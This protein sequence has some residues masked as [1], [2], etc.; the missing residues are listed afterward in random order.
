MHLA[1]GDDDWYGPSSPYRQVDWTP[2]V[3]VFTEARLTPVTVEDGMT[4][5]AVRTTALPAP[6][7]S[8]TGFT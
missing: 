2:N 7:V 3:H 8:W 6:A 5:W 4:L 1:P